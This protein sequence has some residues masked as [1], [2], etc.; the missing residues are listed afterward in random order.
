MVQSAQHHPTGDTHHQGVTRA[1]WWL[2]D[3][4]R[5][6]ADNPLIR[7]F[8]SWSL[9]MRCPSATATRV[10][11][12]ETNVDATSLPPLAAPDASDD[13]RTRAI[14]ARIV[15]RYDAQLLED[16][17]RAYAGFG[18]EWPGDKAALRS[19]VHSAVGG[20]H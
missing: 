6:A 5:H 10:T 20:R 8:T 7:W 9:S 15:A 3:S 11:P 17:R 12:H 1:S 18:A 14:M 19:K 4:F 13:D 2:R 16:Y